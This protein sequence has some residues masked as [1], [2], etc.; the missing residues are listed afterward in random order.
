M[1]GATVARAVVAGAIAASVSTAVAHDEAEALKVVRDGERDRAYVLDRDGVDVIKLS[2]GH[3]L[4][5]VT[6]AG[7]VWVDEA[8][9]APPD[10]ALGPQGEVI[11]TSNV[12]PVLWRIDRQTLGTTV[13]VLVLDQDRDKDVGF[14]RLRWSPGLRT[15][16]AWT[17]SGARW[18]IDPALAKAWK[19]SR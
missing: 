8:Y 15:F 17:D 12:L 2:T 4:A 5:R 3:K 13:H 1:F 9:S 16:A 18:H 19:I 7:W 6:L 10:V 14:T 11:V